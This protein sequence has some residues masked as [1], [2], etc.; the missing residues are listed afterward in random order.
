[1]EVPHHHGMVAQLQMVT[2]YI[3][4]EARKA[5]KVLI[6]EKR[7]LSPLHVF[8]H[9][10]LSAQIAE[11]TE[12]IEE[13][14][15][16]RAS[17]LRRAGCNE[18][19]GGN[20][21]Q[22]RM[23]TI[24]GMLQKIDEQERKLSALSEQ[25]MQKHADLQRRATQVD[26]DE[27]NTARQGVRSKYQDATKKKLEETFGEKYSLMRMMDSRKRTNWLLKAD[28]TFDRDP[29]QQESGRESELL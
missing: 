21:L 26:V 18:D 29:R 2:R 22:K 23:A 1:M 5:R 8:K 3:A 11:K 27:L 19:A 7:E 6:A 9:K 24:E 25:T 4:L 13:L 14:K 16:R 20:E 15:T 28:R 12:D 10:E 17:I